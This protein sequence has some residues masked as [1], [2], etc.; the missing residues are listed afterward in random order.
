M[1]RVESVECQGR[2][3]RPCRSLRCPPHTNA[4]GEGTSDEKHQTS[5]QK[6]SFFLQKKRTKKTQRPQKTTERPEKH[7]NTEKKKGEKRNV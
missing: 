2:S 1:C 4:A 6:N 7:R 3:G 5:M